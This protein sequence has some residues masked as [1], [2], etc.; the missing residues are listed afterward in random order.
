M[1]INFES[2][3]NEERPPEEA[4]HPGQDFGNRILI[5]TMISSVFNPPGQENAYKTN[6]YFH[7]IE[8]EYAYEANISL[9]RFR[10][11]SHLCV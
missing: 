11:E 1:F 8:C 6:D 4:R 7:Y 5:K 2:E 3:L 10:F 9:M